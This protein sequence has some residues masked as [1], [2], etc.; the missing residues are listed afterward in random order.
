MKL[1]RQKHCVATLDVGASGT[2]FVMCFQGLLRAKKQKITVFI[3]YQEHPCSKCVSQRYLGSSQTNKAG[4][5]NNSQQDVSSE[6]L[7]WEAESV[8]LS[9]KQASNALC[10]KASLTPIHEKSSTLFGEGVS[11]IPSIKNF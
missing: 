9:D 4:C 7:I 8:N 10:I 3:V 6:G 11:S 2:C 5:D 1:Y